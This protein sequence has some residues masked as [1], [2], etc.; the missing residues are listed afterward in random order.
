MA[1]VVGCSNKGDSGGTATNQGSGR[2]T[3]PAPKPVIIEIPTGL[4]SADRVA[5]EHARDALL[6]ACA[7]TPL[8]PTQFQEVTL[9][10]RQALG[11]QKDEFDWALVVT[12]ALL[13]KEGLDNHRGGHRITFDMELETAR[14]S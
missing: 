3:V 4:S 8:D 5:A 1:V 7:K 11:Y 10:T 12:V 2:T 6:A 13:Y 14:G 9:S